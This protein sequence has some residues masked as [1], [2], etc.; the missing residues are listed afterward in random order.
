M[1]NDLQKRKLLAKRLEQDS[2][3]VRDNSMSV[4]REYEGLEAEGLEGES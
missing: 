2:Y 3:L 4:L 1:Y